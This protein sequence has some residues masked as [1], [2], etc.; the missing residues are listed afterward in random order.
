MSAFAMFIKIA[1]SQEYP[2]KR[3][4]ISSSLLPDSAESAKQP[5]CTPFAAALRQ[6]S[7]DQLHDSGVG[8]LP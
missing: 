1:V 8:D 2:T 7:L 3:T 5:T 6:I 4:P